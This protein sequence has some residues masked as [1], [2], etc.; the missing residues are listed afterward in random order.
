MSDPPLAAPPLRP[1]AQSIALPIA[2]LTLCCLFWGFSFPGMQI[3]AAI[4]EKTLASAAID[5]SGTRGELASRSIFNAWRFGIASAAF[6]LLTFPRRRHFSRADLLVGLV[7][8]LSFC[9]GILLQLIGF[10]YT[11]PFTPSF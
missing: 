3:S 11:L 6:F 8:V 4:F 2:V 7:T 10:R 9:I 5:I 1:I